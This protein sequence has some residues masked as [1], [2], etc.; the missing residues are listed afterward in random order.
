MSRLTQTNIAKQLLIN[1]ILFVGTLLGFICCCIAFQWSKSTISPESEIKKIQEIVQDELS[2]SE[3]YIPANM[4]FPSELDKLI[5]DNEGQDFL[6]L[7]LNIY[8]ENRLIF[9]NHPEIIDTSLQSKKAVWIDRGQS[10]TTLRAINIFDTKQGVKAEILD[11]IESQYRFKASQTSQNHVLELPDS[12][13]P[14][15][16]SKKPNTSKAKNLGIVSLLFFFLFLYALLWSFFNRYAFYYGPFKA[17]MIVTI[18]AFTIKWV[19]TLLPFHEIY[20]QTSYFTIDNPSSF[21]HPSPFDF[22]IS[23]LSLLFIC[24]VLA[25]IP[26][27]KPKDLFQLPGLVILY[28]LPIALWILF[29]Y[30]SKNLILTN[31]SIVDA[32]QMVSPNSIRLFSFLSLTGILLANFTLHFKISQLSKAWNISNIGKIL[33]FAAAGAINFFPFTKLVA[34]PN[35]FLFLSGL[36]VIFLIQD[37]FADTKRKNLPWAIWW[38][39]LH[40]AFISALI[41][42]QAFTKR[43]AERNDFLQSVYTKDKYVDNRNIDII[44]TDILQSGLIDKISDLPSPLKF[45]KKDILEFQNSKWSNKRLV[46][47]FTA[48]DVYIFDSYGN[49]YFNHDFSNEDDLIQEIQFAKHIS[50]DVYYNPFEEKYILKYYTENESFPGERLRIYFSLQKKNPN[51]QNILHTD[52][53]VY[54]NG[55]LIKEENF[56]NSD[57][58]QY[59]NLSAGSFFINRESIIVLDRKEGIK[60]VSVERI[61][62]LLKPISIFSFCFLFLGILLSLIALLNTVFPFLPEGLQLKFGKTNSLRTRLQIMVISLV[63]LAFFFIG[64][65]SFYYFKN[66]LEI[67]QQEE[68]A[69]ELEKIRKDVNSVTRSALDKE[70]SIVILSNSLKELS[71]IHGVDLSLYNSNAFLVNSSQSKKEANLDFLTASVFSKD[72]GLASLTKEKD[73]FVSFIALQRLNPIPYGYLEV[74]HKRSN[75]IRDRLKDFVSTILNLYVFLFLLAGAIAISIANSISYPLTVLSE[76]LKQTKLGKKNEKLDWKSN[77]E[78]GVLIKEYNGMLSQLEESALLLAKNERDHAWREMAKQVAHEVKNPLT[79][80]KLSVQSLNR[81]IKADPDNAEALIKKVS[82]TLVEQ[83]DTLAEIANSFSSLAKMPI[84]TKE[85]ISLNRIIEQVYDLF[86]EENSN[87]ELTLPKENL[88]VFADGKQ[89]TRVLNNLVKNAL[90]AIPEDRAA[91]IYL[92]LRRIGDFAQIEVK[93]NGVGIPEDK[94]SQIFTP[95]FTTKSTGSGLGLAMCANIVET[96][97]GKIYFETEEHVGTRFYVEIPLTISSAF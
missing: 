38:I 55:E 24:A 40:S 64:L 9:W 39:L 67:S 21:W 61:A 43:I 3:K 30:S 50:P 34:F 96:L 51:Q 53:A 36:F 86:D 85:E 46:E 89:L 12:S 28:C 66:V 75:L 71:S 42:G 56:G 5:N 16:F 58:D 82:N 2:S 11:K 45:E 47:K 35:Y 20:Y 31:L 33:S 88:I 63:I 6:T 17:A 44:K 1:K 48:I 65:A 54:K 57:I 27:G 81:A 49:A 70:G 68:F 14:L 8:K 72:I 94:R 78:I 76:K 7:K 83:I 79:P 92:K 10:Y 18:T 97:Q 93:D 80:M 69:T 26:I 90:Q 22:S 62:S 4:D 59:A 41:F 84:A 23:S 29:S 37:L 52:F 19:T 87:F 77:D 91:Q 15:S 32:N 74:E 60:L 73:Q 95:N 25:R 13:I